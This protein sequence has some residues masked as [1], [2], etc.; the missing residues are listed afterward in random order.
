MGL[1]SA[2]SA[3]TAI[4]KLKMGKSAKL[5]LAQIADGI[6]NLQDAYKKLPS[7]EFQRV[8]DLYKA[9]QGAKT[10][11]ELHSMDDYYLYAIDIIKKFDKIA[12]YELYSGGN[13][14]EFSLFMDEIRGIDPKTESV[15]VEETPKKTANIPHEVS[16][17][18]ARENRE[19]FT[20]REECINYITKNSNGML[21][22]QDA[23]R[24]ADILLICAHQGKTKAVEAFYNFVDETISLYS[25]NP[26]LFITING[27]CKGALEAN[28]IINQAEAQK[29]SA[30][31]SD[32]TAKWLDETRRKA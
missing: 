15:E 29:M 22:R 23:E 9:F 17:M 25:D 32:R 2:I 8:Y 14:L 7:E 26:G 13:E 4:R 21:S 19:A 3:L 28:G 31:I 10:K 1:F 16:G 6:I 27:F 20:E 18:S 11:L 5:S 30:F 24:F 12:P